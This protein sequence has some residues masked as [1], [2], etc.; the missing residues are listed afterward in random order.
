MIGSGVEINA[1]GLALT[2]GAQC[3]VSVVGEKVLGTHRFDLI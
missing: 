3:Y 1:L 2:F